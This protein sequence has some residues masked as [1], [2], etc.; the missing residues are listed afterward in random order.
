M[1]RQALGVVLMMTSEKVKNFSRC[2]IDI[3]TNLSYISKSVECLFSYFVDRKRHRYGVIENDANVTRLICR[4]D[5]K[6]LF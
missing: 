3:L 4:R 6:F 5:D 1:T 2:N